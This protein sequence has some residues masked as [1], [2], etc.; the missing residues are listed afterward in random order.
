MPTRRLFAILTGSIAATSLGLALAVVLEGCGNAPG[1]TGGKRVVLHTRVTIAEEALSTFTTSTGW[2]VTLSKAAVAAGPFYYFN[3]APP[4]VLRAG[5][6]TWRWAARV[7][8]LSQAH[9]HPGHYQPGDALG[10]MLE[11]SSLD[12][13]AGPVDFPDG[14]GITGTYRSARFTVAPPAGPAQAELEGHS[15]LAAGIAEKAG[16]TPRFF[17]AVADLS[18][19]EEHAS[20]GRIEGCDLT[21]VDVTSD[22]TITVSVDPQIWFR[23]VDFTTADAG[24]AE[25][26]ADFPDDSDP[27]LAFLLGVTQ[28]SAY[29][30]SYEPQ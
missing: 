10:Q 12:L 6:P 4:V 5:Q 7:L 29:Q 24:S 13:L 19:V 2:D 22:G 23:L 25:A 11:T 17:R 28:L 8:G 21:K 20:Q 18:Q 27:Q 14:D 3:G 9:A 26:P 1:S 16:E 30:F 15:V